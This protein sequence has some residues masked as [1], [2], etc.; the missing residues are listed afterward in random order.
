MKNLF[1]KFSLFCKE[2]ASEIAAVAL[3]A[4]LLQWFNINYRPAYDKAHDSIVA[5]I[6]IPTSERRADMSQAL[7]SC[8]YVDSVLTEP[9]RI[10]I[11]AD[12]VYK[13]DLFEFM[14]KRG[15]G[16]EM[17]E[18][19]FFESPY[20]DEERNARYLEQYTGDDFRINL[21]VAQHYVR[22]GKGYSA[23][24]AAVKAFVNSN[25]SGAREES[26]S[27]VRAILQH[28][29]CYDEFHIWGEVTKGIAE[30]Q[31]NFGSE[32]FQSGIKDTTNSLSEDLAAQRARLAQGHI[33]GLG[34]KCALS[35]YGKPAAQ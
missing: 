32:P 20:A 6:D 18:F 9:C 2:H 30:Q 17:V 4:A 27:Y 3:F 5:F 21:F 15:N 19:R 25:T 12:P 26:G 8:A 13:K 24:L 14:A 33:P 35:S 28:Y 16:F 31:L 10:K 23:Y 7:N 29:A 1:A 11:A 22:I 34:E